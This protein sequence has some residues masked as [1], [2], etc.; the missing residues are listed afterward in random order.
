MDIEPGSREFFELAIADNRAAE[1][2]EGWNLP[3]L[4]ELA[5]QIDL[6][7][8]WRPDEWERLIADQVAAGMVANPEPES[9]QTEPRTVTCPQCGHC[10]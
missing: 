8:F 10:F 4:A 5:A 6:N 9:D 1:L 2:A 7:E 3:V